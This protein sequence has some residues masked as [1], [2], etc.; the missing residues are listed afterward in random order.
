M[1]VRSAFLGW[2]AGRI[3]YHSPP[4]ASRNGRSAPDAQAL[5]QT[6]PKT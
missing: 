6:A 2:V 4:I 5:T 3:A 1:T